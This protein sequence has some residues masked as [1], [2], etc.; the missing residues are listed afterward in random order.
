M[1][2]GIV[3]QGYQAIDTTKPLLGQQ[4]PFP[5]TLDRG[6]DP[7]WPYVSLLLR[8][9]GNN[10][11]TQF[12]NESPVRGVAGTAVG[13]AALSNEASRFGHTSLRTVPN[14]NTNFVSFGSNAAFSMGTGPF[15]A[16]AFIRVFSVPAANNGVAAVCSVQTSATAAANT[17]WWFGL[18]NT[19][20]VN[21]LAIGIHNSSTIAR[22]PWVPIFGRW[23]HVAVTRAAGNVIRIFIDGAQQSLLTVGTFTNNF[24]ATGTFVVGYSVSNPGSL[25][26]NISEFRLTKGVARYLTSFSPPT[27]PFPAF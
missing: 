2:A 25:D 7:Y 17:M 21:S 26:G 3:A 12:L 1:N 5:M 13:T 19:S 15:T 24:S 18:R 16:E 20:G 9:D 11:S 4:S 10:G 23:Y 27:A 14:A 6:G 8:F 22:A